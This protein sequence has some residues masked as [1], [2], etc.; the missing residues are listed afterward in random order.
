MSMYLSADERV[1]VRGAHTFGFSESHKPFSK[2]VTLTTFEWQRVIRWIQCRH[3]RELPNSPL[4]R[5]RTI[6]S[7][8]LRIVCLL[9]YRIASISACRDTDWILAPWAWDKKPPFMRAPG[10]DDDWPMFTYWF[11][12]RRPHLMWSRHLLFD[13]FFVW[14]FFFDHLNQP[15]NWGWYKISVATTATGCRPAD[16][17]N[18]IIRVAL[19]VLSVV[20]DGVASLCTRE[21]LLWSYKFFVDCTRLV[22]RALISYVMSFHEKSPTTCCMINLYD[23][24]ER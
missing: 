21:T 13:S 11:P 19:N 5:N 14:R 2:K 24:V 22:S 12:T 9:K 1:L 7:W 18:V 8:A 4:E 20:H 15:G 3:G 23:A 16:R 6:T 10:A 17:E